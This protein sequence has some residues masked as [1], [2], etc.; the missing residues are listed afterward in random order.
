MN[1][2]AHTLTHDI[3]EAANHEIRNLS[4]SEIE[5]VNG[6]WAFLLPAAKWGGA[7]F[8]GGFLAQ[9]GVNAANW[10]WGK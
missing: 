6:G 3:N 7:A 1:A 8:A 2:M 10:L 4:D 9:N 5:G